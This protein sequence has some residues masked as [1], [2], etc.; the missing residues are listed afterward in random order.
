M[1][2]WK[3]HQGFYYR[4]RLKYSRFRQW[5]PGACDFVRQVAAKYP[6]AI[7]SGALRSEICYILRQ[8]CLNK[9]FS[10]LVAAEDV[11]NGKPHPE[12]FLTAMK[13]LNKKLGLRLK[14]RECLVVEDSLEGI[15]AAR[16]AG[17]RCLAL[18]TSHP[19]SKLRSADAV[20]RNYRQI[21]LE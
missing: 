8:G 7:A 14:P 10:V 17:M 12:G 2:E 18:A 4:R 15:E 9:Y 3:R 19:M 1:G 6:L 21:R 20:V 11:R 16:R 5:F 13:I